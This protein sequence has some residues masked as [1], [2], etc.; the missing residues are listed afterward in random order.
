[1]HRGLAQRI[2]L[3]TPV[4]TVDLLRVLEP[5]PPL[6]DEGYLGRTLRGAGLGVE[7]A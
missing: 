7:L 1:M 2:S 4:M 3:R 6:G 5:D